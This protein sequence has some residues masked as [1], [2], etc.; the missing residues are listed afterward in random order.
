MSKHEFWKKYGTFILYNVYGFSATLLE[1]F[2][3]WLLYRRLGM[4]NVPA[5]IVS[6]FI[7]ITYA[8]F[9]NKML[10][11]MSTD[12]RL[13]TLSKEIGEFY[14]FRILTAF[15]NVGYMYVTVSLLHW[16]PVAM[17]M[18][19]ALIV[20]W[21]NYVLGKKVVFKN[22]RHHHNQKEQQEEQVE[23]QEEIIL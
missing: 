15:F 3:Y 6:T 16:A 5:T 7:T 10:V 2:L 1:T 23:P 19:S 12:W 20:G 14:G 21:M 4:H 17:K 11:Y 9:T 22:R 8:F 13:K 18:I